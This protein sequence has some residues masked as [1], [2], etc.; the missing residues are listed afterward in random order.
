VR[1]SARA[2]SGAPPTVETEEMFALRLRVTR[3]MLDL[4]EEIDLR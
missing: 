3:L 2:V 1:Y 4:A